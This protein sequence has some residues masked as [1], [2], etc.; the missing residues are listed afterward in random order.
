MFYMT[1]KL[2]SFKLYHGLE[3][4][5]TLTDLCHMVFFEEEKIISYSILGGSYKNQ[6]KQTFP[7][8]LLTVFNSRAMDD[9]FI[10][11]EYSSIF[12]NLI[13]CQIL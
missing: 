4:S 10:D 2:T 5:T 9:L 12:L 11:G 1:S 3:S 6:I 7:I 8:F 13:S